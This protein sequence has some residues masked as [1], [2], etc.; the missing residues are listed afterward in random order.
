MFENTME[1][2]VV[3]KIQ[4]FTSIQNS[5]TAPLTDVFLFLIRSQLVFP[6]FTHCPWRECTA[7]EQ[8]ICRK[9]TR[10]G[11]RLTAESYVTNKNK[12]IST[13]KETTRNTVANCHLTTHLCFCLG[14]GVLQWQRGRRGAVSKSL[15]PGSQ[16]DV[17]HR[18]PL[19]PCSDNCHSEGMPPF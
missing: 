12:K 3:W 2:H 16:V 9:I 14:G 15:K 7:T 1:R 5:I 10:P 18:R 13:L 6:T 8:D 4:Y 11:Y 19:L 17:D